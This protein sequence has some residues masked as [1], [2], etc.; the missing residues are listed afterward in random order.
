[1]KPTLLELYNLYI[2]QTY[3]GFWVFIYFSGLI[4]ITSLFIHLSKL[5]LSNKIERKKIKVPFLS[6]EL[7]KIKLFEGIFMVLAIQIAISLPFKMVSYTHNFY[8]KYTNEYS[9]GNFNSNVLKICEDL[10][11]GY[12][13]KIDIEILYRCVVESEKELK[14]DVGK[15]KNGIPIFSLN[16]DYNILLSNVLQEEKIPFIKKEMSFEKLDHIKI[17]N[18]AEN[19]STL[20]PVKLERRHKYYS[21]CG[22]KE[23]YSLKITAYEDLSNFE[24]ISF[25]KF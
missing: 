15:I 13:N 5:K 17:L 24:Y 10:Y 11:K 4:C 23:N 1:M 20:S 22:C 16:K 9:A 6:L 8:L 19:F 12:D 18:V 21:D 3:G 2:D 7:D 14:L 25:R